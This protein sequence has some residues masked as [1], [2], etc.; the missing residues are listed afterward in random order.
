MRAAFAPTSLAPTR[1]LERTSITLPPLLETDSDHN[2]VL[3]TE[4]GGGVSGFDPTHVRVG[5]HDFPTHAF[6]GVNGMIEHDGGVNVG[7]QRGECRDKPRVAAW[8]LP[9]R[10]NPPGFGCVGTKAGQ[11]R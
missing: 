4:P 11:S 8:P 5:H 3:E 6:G 7:A 2:I 1:D 10:G 9:R